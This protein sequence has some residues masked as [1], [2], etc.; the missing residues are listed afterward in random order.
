[1]ILTVPKADFLVRSAK[2][3][4]SGL[5]IVEF[6]NYDCSFCKKTHLTLLDFMQRHP[7]INYV[8]R[9]VP[10]ANGG[11]EQA[12]EYAIAAGLQGKFWEIDKALVDYDAMLDEKILQG[13]GFGLRH[14]LWPHGP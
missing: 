8:V 12:A 11:A 10:Y 3:N 4:H 1:M 9:P 2:G 5:T 14:R 6:V 13:H 7:E